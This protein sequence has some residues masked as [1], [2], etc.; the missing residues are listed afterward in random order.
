MLKYIAISLLTLTSASLITACGSEK[1]DPAPSAGEIT[2][3]ASELNFTDTGGEET[4]TFTTPGEWDAATSSTW[5]HLTKSDQLSTSGRITVAVD[6]NPS[7][8]PR[9]ATVTVRS[10][11]MRGSLTVS[12][13]GYTFVPTNPDIEVPEGY[14]LVWA[15]EFDGSELDRTHWTHEVQS[16]GWINNELQTYVNATYAGTPVSEVSD[17]TL[18]INCFKA[19]DGRIC[20]ARIYADVNTGWTYGIFEAAIRLPKGKGTW[21]AFWMMPAGNDFSTTPWP[22]CGEIDIMEEVGYNPNYTSSTIHCESYNH[23]IGTQKTAERFTSGAQDD[24][25]VYRLEW[26]ADYIRTYVDGQMLLNFPNDGTGN[27]STWPFNRPF[28]LIL[29]LAWGGDWGGAMGVDESVLPATMEVD[30]VR[31]FQK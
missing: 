13:E 11:G 4:V 18:K 31:V 8:D 22:R 1:D 2:L 7:R 30:Y 21:P 10:K 12:Q 20:S 5:I 14:T 3:S 16:P 19:A 23:M 26:T 24:F 6:P 25:H 29:N 15:D 17:G 9:S 27:F 28:Y